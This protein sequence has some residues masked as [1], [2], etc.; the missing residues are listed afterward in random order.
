MDAWET[1]IQ[2]M[3]VIVRQLAK[4]YNTIHVEF[5]EPLN[6]A[7]QNAPAKY[8]VW[9]GVHPMP[10]G[11]ELMARVWINEVSKKLDFIKNAN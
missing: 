10:A 11:H 2:E 9:D 6:K 4:S 7:C 5:Q 1:V 8:W 3:Q